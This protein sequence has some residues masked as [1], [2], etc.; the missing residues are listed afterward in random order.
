[1]QAEAIMTKPVITTDANAT[2]AEAVEL[3][4]SNKISCLPVT[5]SDGALVGIVSKS[6]FLRR[7]ELGTQRTRPRWLEFDLGPGTIADGYARSNGRIVHQVMVTN[8]ISAP[9]GASIADIVNL[10]MQ[11]R[12]NNVP[13]V[14]RNRVVGI[15]TRTDLLRVLIRTLPKP[16]TTLPDD[17]QIRKAILAELQRQSWNGGELIG[18]RVSDGVVELTGAIVDERQ[19]KAAIVAAENVAGI[20]QVKDGL[21]LRTDPFSVMMVS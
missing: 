15:I 5:G 6:D 20:G 9:P 12:I 17:E 18:V 16:G 8:V 13:I 19:R 2:I 1:M 21:H 4:L 14:D 11:H 7:E 10:M 3:M